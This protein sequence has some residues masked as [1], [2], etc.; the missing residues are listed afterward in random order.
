MVVSAAPDQ[1]SALAAHPRPERLPPAGRHPR[2]AA[3]APSPAAGW[4]PGPGSP[5]PALLPSA[6]PAPPGG[7]GRRSPPGAGPGRGGVLARRAQGKARNSLTSPRGQVGGEMAADRVIL[8][9]C[10]VFNKRATVGLPINY[11]G[12]VT[13]LR[14]RF[15]ALWAPPAP[16]LR[17]RG[18]LRGAGQPGRSE[19]SL[20]GSTLSTPRGG[21]QGGAACAGQ[22]RGW[23]GC[24]S[25]VPVP[26]AEGGAK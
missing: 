14:L 18:Q 11:R 5:H 23:R 8:P 12:H 1:S 22:V 24:A 26:A 10:R 20:G 2:R 3:A 17:A 19:P 25:P 4:R 15:I 9:S 13:R 21:G 16:L 7:C 6:S